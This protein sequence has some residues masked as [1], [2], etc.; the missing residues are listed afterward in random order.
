MLTVARTQDKRGAAESL[1]VAASISHAEGDTP[2]AV[3]AFE[4]VLR[5]YGWYDGTSGCSSRT[6][7]GTTPGPR[8]RR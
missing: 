7:P 6:V 4:G 3:E 8:S 1:L 5:E 2:R